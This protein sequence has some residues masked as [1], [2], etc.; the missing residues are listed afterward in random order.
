MTGRERSGKR[1]K[2]R[3]STRRA[4]AAAHVRRNVLLPDVS[5]MHAICS[6]SCD[7]PSLWSSPSPTSLKPTAIIPAWTASAM[8]S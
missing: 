5:L 7:V 4:A 8:A 1:R 6:V 3:R 2:R